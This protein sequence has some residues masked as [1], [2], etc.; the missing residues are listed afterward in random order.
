MLPGEVRLVLRTRSGP[1][2]VSRSS[3]RHLLCFS[4]SPGHQADDSA[5]SGSFRLLFHTELDVAVSDEAHEPRWNPTEV[6][7]CINRGTSG[8]P[9]QNKTRAGNIQGFTTRHLKCIFTTEKL[10]SMNLQMCQCLLDI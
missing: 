8:T 9:L 4:C 5:D 7:Q 2:A 10:Y 6:R 3:G 1:V